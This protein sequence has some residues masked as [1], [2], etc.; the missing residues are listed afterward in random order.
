MLSKPTLTE[1]THLYSTLAP[2]E[3]DELPQY[4][5]IAAVRGAQV[6]L[7]VLEA[8]LLELAGRE[9]IAELGVSSPARLRHQD[10]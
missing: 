10:P 4:L 7:D 5:L 9:L 1:L 2:K 6:A 8:A 3:R